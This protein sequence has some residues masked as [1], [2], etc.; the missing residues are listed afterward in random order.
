MTVTKNTIIV[1]LVLTCGLLA[2]ILLAGLPASLPVHPAKRIISTGLA[3]SPIGPYS[4]AIGSGDFVFL[5]GQIGIDPITGNLTGSIDGQTT[6][7]MD[8]LRAV[9]QKSGL[10][11]S[12]IVSTRIYLVNMS[13]GAAVNG[14]YASYFNG[15]YPARATVQVSGLPKGALVEIEMVAQKRY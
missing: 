2:G 3:P 4:Q 15:T 7:T 1:V 11:F 12:D 5:S 13:D 10:D 8:N 14:I 6:R 9:L